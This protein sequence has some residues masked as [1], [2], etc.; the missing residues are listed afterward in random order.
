MVAVRKGFSRRIRQIFS[1]SLFIGL[2]LPAALL[3]TASP[4]FASVGAFD[5]SS[6]DGPIFMEDSN[7]GY[8]AREL[9]L[10]SA[11]YGSIIFEIHD[12]ENGRSWDYSQLNGIAINPVDGKAYG[13]MG[14]VDATSHSKF[15]VRFDDDEDVEFIAKVDVAN[16]SATIDVHGDYLFI[17]G[18][19][20]GLYRIENV[21]NLTGYTDP[22]NNSILDKTTL[23]SLLSNSDSS[24]GGG[25]ADIQAVRADLDLGGIEDYVI[26]I[27]NSNSGGTKVTVARY[28]GSTDVWHLTPDTTMPT[29]PWRAA[30]YTD[31][32]L[33]FQEKKGNI[34]ELEIQDLN[35]IDLSAGTAD[36]TYIDD[37]SGI[38]DGDGMACYTSPGFTVT[39]TGGSTVVSETGTTDTFTV[40]LNS[41]PAGDVQIDLTNPDTGEATLDDL[42]LTFNTSNWNTPQTVTATG[43]DDLYVDGNQNQTVTFSVDDSGTDDN[44]YDPGQRK[45]R[46]YCG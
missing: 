28:S 2:A 22:N 37:T 36:V 30:W 29:R 13:V 21:A 27:R 15:L 39:Q 23:S 38:Q 11:A 7:N 9:N 10:S 16:T 1:L 42:S 45:R 24:W 34:Y 8:E 12:S 44:R 4:A 31:G 14:G 32:R 33:L 41:K 20:Y 25:I 5:C 19:N 26:G 18:N 3:L 17:G 6:Y 35:D 46:I 43:V 40:V